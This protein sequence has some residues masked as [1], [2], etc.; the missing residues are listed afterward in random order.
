MTDRDDDMTGKDDQRH[1]YRDIDHDAAQ[2]R[3]L[4]RFE[5]NNFKQAAFERIDAGL[6]ALDEQLERNKKARSL[7]LPKR[8]K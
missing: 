5:V 8:R 2:K 7:Q 6:K 1:C 4:E 3:A